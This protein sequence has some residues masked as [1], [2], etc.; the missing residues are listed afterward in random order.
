MVV[1]VSDQEAR[2]RHAGAAHGVR[3]RGARY[4]VGWEDADNLNGVPKDF[5]VDAIEPLRRELAVHQTPV[6][7]DRGV[8]ANVRDAL[9]RKGQRNEE[10]RKKEPSHVSASSNREGRLSAKTPM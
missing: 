1:G 5:A 9:R 8:D 6:M 4:R 10:E 7:C 2:E 3:R